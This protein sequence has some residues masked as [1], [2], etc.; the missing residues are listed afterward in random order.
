MSK[1]SLSSSKN[2]ISHKPCKSYIDIKRTFKLDDEIFNSSCTL[3]AKKKTPIFPKND[4]YKTQESYETLFT[5]PSEAIDYKPKNFKLNLKLDKR[6]KECKILKKRAEDECS[7]HEILSEQDE[8]IR[9][10]CDIIERLKSKNRNLKKIIQKQEKM[11]EEMKNTIKD[12]RFER[13]WIEEQMKIVKEKSKHLIKENNNSTQSNEKIIRRCVELEAYIVEMGS[14]E[15]KCKGKNFVMNS[16]IDQYEGIRKENKLLNEKCKEIS[17]KFI[18]LELENKFFK[19]QEKKMN[20][21]IEMLL[22]NRDTK[23]VWKG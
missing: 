1:Q 16:I 21:K 15:E 22:E 6:N 23:S 7:M 14:D 13:D 17:E 3:E 5:D 20:K 9:I 10:Q 11:L 2:L 18:A 12:E 19:L 8:I 4:L